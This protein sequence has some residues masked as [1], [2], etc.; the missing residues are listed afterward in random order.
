MNVEGNRC[1]A[2]PA[3]LRGAGRALLFDNLKHGGL[4]REPDD[5][6]QYRAF[7]QEGVSG[8]QD[9]GR[10]GRQQTVAQSCLHCHM[11]AK[12]A[13]G[14][15]SLFGHTA[16]AAGLSSAGIQGIAV[17]MDSGPVHTYPHGERSARWKLEQ[18]EYLRLVEYAR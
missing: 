9:W 15:Y 1:L 7:L 3:P 18:E 17:P 4:K 8:A 2:P 16:G 14:L 13:V 11:F 12:D 6:P 10:Y 5:L